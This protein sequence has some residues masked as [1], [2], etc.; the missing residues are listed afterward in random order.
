MRNLVVIDDRKIRK[1]AFSSVHRLLK[2]LQ[3]MEA[4]L[5]AFHARD[6]QLYNEWYALTFRGRRLA[7]DQLR[8][9]Y[10][11]LAEFHNWMVALAEM[12][13]L[14]FPQ[15]AYILSE[16]ARVYRD[17]TFEQR[18]E[19]ERRRRL[20]EEYVRD[21]SERQYRRREKRRARY[22]RTQESTRGPRPL[23]PED[24][25]ELETMS[26]LSDSELED[27][28]ADSDAAFDLLGKS[29]RQAARTEEFALF[30]R[31]WGVLHP[32]QQKEFAKEFRKHTGG[33][34]FETIEQMRRKSREPE[35]EREPLKVETFKLLYRQL[36]RKLHPDMHARTVRKDLWREQM[37]LRVQ[38]AY[39]AE[40]EQQL[41]KLYHLVLLRAGELEGL[42]L[43][44]LHITQKW[45]NDEIGH[46][47]EKLHGLRRQPAWGFSRRKDLTPI[48]RKI[49]RQLAKDFDKL[50][51]EVI[52]LRTRQAFLERMGREEANGSGRQKRS[53]A[54]RRPEQMSLF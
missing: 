9:E 32:K 47:E 15:A 18:L 25:E 45:L 13:D 6:Q 10:N 2:K 1:Q 40:D 14:S 53:S 33:S 46:A 21:E 3:R 38:A 51:Q 41:H 26:S 11:D 19:I 30:L 31:L 27:W 44:E 50:E 23:D 48:T 16:E 54:H 4:G 7:L 17:G 37:W 5:E 35:N 8:G 39:Q 52:A 42:R 29:L 28:C 49:D 12:E 24:I 36:A 22:E 20:R 43:S 34:L